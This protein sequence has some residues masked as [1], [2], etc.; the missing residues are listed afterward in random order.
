MNFVQTNQQQSTAKTTE[1]KIFVGLGADNFN[2]V[3]VYVAIQ[4]R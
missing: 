2:I 3:H 4:V 1:S